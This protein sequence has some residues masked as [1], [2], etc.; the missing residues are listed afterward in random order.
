M[1]KNWV[2]LIVAAASGCGQAFRHSGPLPPSNVRR[3]ALLPIVNKTQQSGLEDALMQRTRDEF[4]RDGRC[5][6]VPEDQADDVVR[7]TLTRYLNIPAQYD[8]SLAPTAYKMDIRAD[9]E[10]LDAKKRGQALW[11]EKDLSELESYAAPALAGGLTEAQAQVDIWDIMS[12][13][14]VQRVMDGLSSAPPAA[15]AASP[16]Q[17]TAP[18]G[19]KTR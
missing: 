3:L 17:A 13:D 18:A 16:Q 9:V 7:I 19:A 4:L 1:R 15:S 11:T 14:I 5:P 6:L 12:R 8:S 2:L 10:F